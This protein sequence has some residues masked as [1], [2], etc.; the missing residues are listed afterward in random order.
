MS[1][2]LPGTD[3]SRDHVVGQ[4]LVAILQ[5]GLIV[6]D[7]M[8]WVYT[9]FRLDNGAVFA[10]PIEDAGGFLAEA[11]RPECSR[12]DYPELTPVLGQRIVSVLRDGPDSDVC[13]DSPYLIMENGYI[14]TDV[15]GYP[16]GPGYAG[17]DVYAPGVAREA[18]LRAGYRWTVHGPAPVN[19]GVRRSSRA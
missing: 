7:G 8:E 9:Y 3:L 18:G 11:P 13:H 4:R 19:S 2:I 12:Q 15:M 6:E 10:L 17:L 16:A 5:S 14:V 1:Q